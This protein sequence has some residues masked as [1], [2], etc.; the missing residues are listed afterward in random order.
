M[1][2]L[3]RGYIHQAAFFIAL[4]AC[5]LLIAQSHGAR[6]LSSNIIYSLTLTGMFGVSALYHCPM[7]NRR[8]Y[9]LMRSI[10]H[11]AIFAFVA[12]SATPICLLGLNNELGWRLLSILWII[13]AI[14]MFSAIFWTQGP[15]WIRAFLYI[16]IGWL[17]VPYL[18]EMR[19]SFGIANTQLLLIGGIIYTVG[20]LVY[21]V[22]RPDPFPRIFGYHEIFHIL[23]VI[24]SAFYFR[25]IYSLT[26]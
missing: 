25:V 4:G 13:A 23:V 1:K 6:A 10:D 7:W 21:A 16:S 20:A 3:T 9:L 5:S 14:G 2:P 8:N 19:S 22:K 18:S 11:A 17:A 24:A 15:K 12:G 26:I